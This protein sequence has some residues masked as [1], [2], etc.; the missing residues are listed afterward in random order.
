MLCYWSLRRAL[1]RAS[2]A[3]DQTGL[4]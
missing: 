3:A 2:E 1:A 4:L